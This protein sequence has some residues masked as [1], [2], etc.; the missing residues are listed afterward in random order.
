MIKFRWLSIPFLLG[1]C[2]PKPANQQISTTEQSSTTD[3]THFDQPVT[4]SPKPIAEVLAEHTPEWMKIPGV[5]G[6]GEGLKDGKPAILILVD[7]LTDSL[8]AQLPRVSE[9]YPVVITVTGRV[10]TDHLR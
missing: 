2:A 3:S 4:D 6:T 1:A 7:S 10:R 5:T 8:K 9:G